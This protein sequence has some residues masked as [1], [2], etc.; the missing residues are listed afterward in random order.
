ME[1]NREFVFAADLGGT[2]LRAA[3][4]DNRG[5]VHYRLKLRTPAAGTADAIVN[6]LVTA[7]REC[8]DQCQQSAVSIRATCVAVPGT[9][10]A[11]AGSIV[12]MPKLLCLEGF[13]L[14]DVLAKALGCPVIL[15][16]DANAA[17][18][19]EM[20]LGAA[21]GRQSIVCLTL[22]TGV[23]AGIILEGKLWRGAS[24]SAAEI[25]HTW[26]DP[27]ADDACNCGSRGCLEL[28]ASASAIVR[29]TR[30]ARARYSNSVL[31]DNGELTAEEVYTAGVKGDELAIE[32]FRR[33]GDYLGVGLANLMSVLNP[34]MIVIGGG[35]ADGWDLFAEA[36]SRRIAQR[37]FPLSA[38]RIP[39]VRAECGDDAGL[40]GAARLGF[41]HLGS[42]RGGAK[43]VS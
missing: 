14:A 42:K 33:M 8:E 32:V 16:N 39:V 35:A 1:T 4:I 13:P 27:F 22:G 15:E 31:P 26:V 21:R 3:L 17:A 12:Q 2:H 40:L 18:V 23:G 30:E 25:G 11:D 10:N 28:Y 43:A 24:G 5:T 34:E 9:V 20:W 37:S 41:D 29:M 7:A 38:M 36:M 19:G 6:A